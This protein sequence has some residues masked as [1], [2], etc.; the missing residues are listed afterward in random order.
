VK[1]ELTA[2]D[3]EVEAA[4][5]AIQ[6]GLNAFGNGHADLTI[7]P[8]DDTMRLSPSPWTRSRAMP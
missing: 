3:H 7:L 5:E 6:D 8:V 1:L 4:I 2:L